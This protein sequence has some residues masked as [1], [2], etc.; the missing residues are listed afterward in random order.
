MSKENCKTKFQCDWY[1]IGVLVGFFVFFICSISFVYYLSLCSRLNFSQKDFRLDY[2]SYNSDL[3][4]VNE[5]CSSGSSN[6]LSVCQIYSKRLKFADLRMAHINYLLASDKVL[7]NLVK[8]SVQKSVVC[9]SEFRTVNYLVP[10]SINCAAIAIKLS[11]TDKQSEFEIQPF[12]IQNQYKNIENNL[13]AN[14]LVNNIESK[15]FLK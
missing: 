13:A 3:V 8:T 2:A 10:Q 12:E 14:Q 11:K 5:N 7:N 15:E 6:F 4:Y 1:F 9:D